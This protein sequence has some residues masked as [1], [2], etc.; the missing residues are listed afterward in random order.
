MILTLTN[1]EQL[2]A[3]LPKFL[4][5]KTKGSL[6]CRAPG[7]PTLR[8]IEQSHLQLETSL[9]FSQ[10]EIKAVAISNR[11]ASNLSQKAAAQC[12]HAVDAVSGGPVR[13]LHAA[14]RQARGPRACP[15]VLCARRAARFRSAHRVGWDVAGAGPRRLW[16]RGRARREATLATWSEKTPP[17]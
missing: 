13:C 17:Y 11:R 5:F 1:L 9:I 4:M 12:R 6:Q 16:G 10:I 15:E 14:P 2:V 8:F 7:A 3:C